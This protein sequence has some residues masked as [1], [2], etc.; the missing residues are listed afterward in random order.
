MFKHGLENKFMKQKLS[1]FGG[2]ELISILFQIKRPSIYGWITR[3]RI[4]DSRLCQLEVLFPAVFTPR[5]V[6]NA[7]G[8]READV[9]KVPVAGVVAWAL[10]RSIKAPDC[11]NL[12][13]IKA[14]YPESEAALA[15]AAELPQ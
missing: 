1:E 13:R 4:P 15:A 6:Y 12:A 8:R 9:L 14:L 2:P 7:A 11:A 3:Q 5:V 10:R